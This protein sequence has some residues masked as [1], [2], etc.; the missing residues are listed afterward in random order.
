MTRRRGREPHAMVHRAALRIGC[1]VTKPDGCGRRRSRA[2]HRAE[3]PSVT[4]EVAFGQSLGL[5]DTRRLPDRQRISARAVGSRSIS[6]RL[7]VRATTPGS[8]HQHAADRYFA[9]DSASH[10]RLIQRHIRRMNTL[11]RQDFILMFRRFREHKHRRQWRPG[12]RHRPMTP[13]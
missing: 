5:K 8:T 4:V 11:P 9:P 1:A 10:S 6:V 12:I 2:A 7:P 3:A 13:V